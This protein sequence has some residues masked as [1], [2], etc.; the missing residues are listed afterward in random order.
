[1]RG[2]AHAL[3]FVKVCLSLQQTQSA[4]SP[5]P[6]R[7]TLDMALKA[8]TNHTML[9][10]AINHTV[11]CVVVGDGMIGKTCMLISY[12]TNGFPTDYIPTIVSPVGFQLTPAPMLT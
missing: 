11:K 8:T 1:M 9:K 12:T 10:A 7:P 3:H 2:P 5:Q 6:T 4:H